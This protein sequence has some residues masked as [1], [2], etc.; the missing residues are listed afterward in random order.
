MI[1]ILRG[2]A[3][4][5]KSTWAKSW[6]ARHKDNTVLVGRDYIRLEILG[7]AKEVKDYWKNYTPRE[8]QQTEEEVTKIERSQI[9][10]AVAQ[11]KDVV[12]DDTHLKLKYTTMPVRIALDYNQAFSLVNFDVDIEEAIRRDSQRE[13]TVGEEVIRMQY[14][15]YRGSLNWGEEEMYQAAAKLP[16]TKWIYPNFEIRKDL[17]CVPRNNQNPNAKSAIITDIDGNIALRDLKKVTRDYYSPP[18]DAY[19]TDVPR[20]NIIKVINSL[21]DSGYSNIILT[22]R[23]ERYRKATEEWLKRHNVKYDFMLMRGDDDM[24]PDDK[25]KYE[26]LQS[27]EDKYKIYIVS[28]DRPKVTQMYL[29]VGLD[30]FNTRRD[31]NDV[32]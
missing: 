26:M 9:L 5:G 7:S 21:K 28:D 19:L 22:G 16:P 8:R 1:Y 30:V 12:V 2:I 6:V 17:K 29:E 11:G 25:V 14:E 27:L 13:M 20:E 31:V 18:V 32:F 23:H 4:S 15:T 10:K 24:R 3:A